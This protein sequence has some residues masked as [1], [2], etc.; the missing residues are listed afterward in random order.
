MK[1]I[2][3]HNGI[4]RERIHRFGAIV[5]INGSNEYVHVKN[6]GR[7]REILVSGTEVFLE[8]HDNPD[9]KTKYSLISAYRGDMLINIDSQV[10]NKVVFDALANNTIRLIS[11]IKSMRREKKFG[12]SRFDIYYEKTDGSAG[13]I[14]VKGVTLD[15]EGAAMFPDAPTPRGRKHL[16]ELAEAVDMGYDAHVFFLIQYK[17]VRIF[18]PNKMT[19]PAFAKA[20]KDTVE[21]GVKIHAYDSIVTEDEIIIGSRV[22]ILID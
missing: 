8:K 5:E 13:Y 18:K 14:E 4:F 1:Y 3:I 9:R 2:N 15:I 22:D 7:C 19:D 16:I 12:T 17:P 10:P 20:L 21:S 6:T 11:D